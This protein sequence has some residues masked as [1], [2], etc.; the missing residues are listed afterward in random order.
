M[1]MSDVCVCVYF[2]RR[3]VLI[4][5]YGIIEA[6]HRWN[7]YLRWD[8]DGNLFVWVWMNESRFGPLNVLTYNFCTAYIPRRKTIYLLGHDGN[9]M[10]DL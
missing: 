1:N 7:T 3:C 8:R 6:R 2:V 5:I 10:D 9:R 4:E